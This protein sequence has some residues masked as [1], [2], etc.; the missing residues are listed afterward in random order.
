M[1]GHKH[2]C[3]EDNLR[4]NSRGPQPFLQ[5]DVSK[6]TRLHLPIEDLAKEA[7]AK[8]L[9]ENVASIDIDSLPWLRSIVG[10]VT[11]Y[12]AEG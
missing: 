12:L 1:I 3:I 6:T 4:T 7:F 5:D 2:K 11:S 10:R 8:A 9:V